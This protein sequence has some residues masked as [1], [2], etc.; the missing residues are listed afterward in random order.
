MIEVA[1]KNKKKSKKVSTKKTYPSNVES[2]A[3]EAMTIQPPDVNEFKMD[4][5]NNIDKF[6]RFRPRHKQ[7][8]ETI[9]EF[10]RMKN[11]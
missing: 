4:N 9:K 2:R 1:K 11:K 8:F 5:E 6:L 10:A 3:K 7:K